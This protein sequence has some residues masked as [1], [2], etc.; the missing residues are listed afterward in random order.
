[1]ERHGVL[2]GSV[3]NG[4]NDPDFDGTLR[5]ALIVHLA[6]SPFLD[7]VSEERIREI[8]RMMSRPPDTVLTHA[9]A[10]EVCQRLGLNAMIEGSVSAVGRATVVTLV[11]SDCTTGDTLARDQAEV[12][13]KEDVLGAVG[14]IASEMRRSLGESGTSLEHHN[15]PIEE[16][17]TTSLEAL[18]AY[19]AGVEKRAA[20]SEIESIAFFERAVE[21]DPGFALA[22]TTLSSIYGAL[23]ETGRGEEYAQ[24]AYD[25]RANVTERERLYIAY[26]Y[27]DRVTGDQLKA[28][29]TLD[30]WKRTYPLD[31]RAPNALALLLTRLGD[32]DR[33][34]A[35]ANEAMRL[36]PAHPFPYS[37]LAFAY[38]G[39]GRYEEARSTGE[40]AMALGIETLPT[41]R[42]LYQLA[43]MA[44]DRTT[45]DRHLEWA[46]A[47]PRGFDLV[48]AHAQVLAFQGRMEAARRLYDE[49]IDSAVRA[50]LPQIA[51]GYAAQAALTEALYGFPND[52]VRRARTVADATAFEPQLRAATALALAGD[53][54]AAEAI[55]R[56]FRD[57]RP[58]DTF[59]HT[60]YMPVAEAALSLARDR[61]AAVI[62][63]LRPAVPIERGTIAALLP[64]YFRGLAQL[65]ERAYRDAAQ[66]F[67]SVLEARGA[68]PFSPVV[69][70]ARL[71]L[72][73][74]LAGEGDTAGSRSAYD[75]LLALWGGADANLPLLLQA[76]AERAALPTAR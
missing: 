31:Y 61:S 62:D 30:V 29:E 4:T 3:A 55:V 49:T 50:R 33:A 17:T 70:L 73:R 9:V 74:A 65:R 63:A 37:N 68:D 26:Q 8:L 6:Q 56:R 34:I 27:H 44:G 12:D 11:A 47:R 5:Q 40:R 48:G 57:V 53:T 15:V 16:G 51:S 14:R 38:R 39:A 66:G 69:L 43:E 42:L 18:K 7:I 59:L 45:A 52:A 72:A 19:T 58:A 2:V 20:G 36:N 60:A 25:H 76:R 32:Y 41:R 67:R 64:M 24:L 75:D 13:R 1:V 46:R 10:S 35:E 54:A 21:L 22:Y 28:R 71:G 23:G